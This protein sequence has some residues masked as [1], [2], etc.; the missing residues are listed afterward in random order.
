MVNIALIHINYILEGH[1]VVWGLGCDQE[2]FVLLCYF[3]N[4]E[5]DA[6]INGGQEKNVGQLPIS[7]HK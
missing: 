6:E 1:S 2:L 5:R 4:F 7:K 3:F